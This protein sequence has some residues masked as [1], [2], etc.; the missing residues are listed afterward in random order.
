MQF[1]L[2]PIFAT[3]WRYLHL[4]QIWPWNALLALPV[5][6]ELVSSSA[7]VN[8]V[9]SAK[10]VLETLGPIDRTPGIPGS[11]KQCLNCKA[12]NEGNL[13]AA[14]HPVRSW[15]HL[16]LGL[17]VPNWL[18][19]FNFS[20]FLHKRMRNHTDCIC[21]E[22]SSA[23][24]CAQCTQLTSAFGLQNLCTLSSTKFKIQRE[25]TPNF[26]LINRKIP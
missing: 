1:A 21:S 17:F 15:L 3:R 22:L 13:L 23:P 4:F 26:K 24:T 16:F 20:N 6:I 14:W 7:G 10:G 12:E 25:I 2:V 8:S 5:S 9:K 19:L 18:H 11:D